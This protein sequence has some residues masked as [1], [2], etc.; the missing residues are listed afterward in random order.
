M[1]FT[2]LAL[3]MIISASGIEE[4][5]EPVFVEVADYY[6][7]LK[8]VVTVTADD[9]YASTTQS[10]E[11]MSTM[12]VGK[13]IYYTGGSHRPIRYNLKEHGTKDAV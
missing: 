5:I 3:G 12:L 6:D 8:A 11:N 10:F 13:H 9:W 4:P 7:N 2:I 1:S